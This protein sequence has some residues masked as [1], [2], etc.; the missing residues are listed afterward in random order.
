[1]LHSYE[2]KFNIKENKYTYRATPS[3]YFRNMLKSKRLNF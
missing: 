1:M 2:S 3:D